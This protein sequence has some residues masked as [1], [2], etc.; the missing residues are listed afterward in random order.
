MQ[1]AWIMLALQVLGQV[2][3]GFD[4]HW[5]GTRY[6]VGS[7]NTTDVSLS[8]F[9]EDG[10]GIYTQNG[11]QVALLRQDYSKRHWYGFFNRPSSAIYLQCTLE[12]D[13]SLF[14]SWK[15]LDEP[16][17]DCYVKASKTEQL[18]HNVTFSV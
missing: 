9:Q 4:G 11:S 7:S 12:D 5:Q 13:S 6:M 14:C 16:Y 3:A 18:N 2:E 15:E 17:Y 8:L 10:T 1:L